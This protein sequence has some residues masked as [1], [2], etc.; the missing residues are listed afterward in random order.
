M[1]TCNLCREGKPNEAFSKCSA[2][3]DG[4]QNYCKECASIKRKERYEVKKDE[5]REQNRQ[6]FQKNQPWKRPEKREYLKAWL[7]ENRDRKNLSNA[8]RKH[9]IR[10]GGGTIRLIDW[11]TLCEKFDNKCLNCGKEEITMDHVIPIS[12]GGAHNIENVQPLCV[13]C[14]CSKGAKT[15]DYRRNYEVDGVG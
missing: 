9:R 2:R 13:S 15:I 8:L 4:L 14:N 12:K 1:K 5:E 6:W 11:L 7:A 3:V 10:A